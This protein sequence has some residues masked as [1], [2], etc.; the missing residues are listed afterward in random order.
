M[1][2]RHNAA[3]LW[4]ASSLCFF[5][6][7]K[8]GG[9]VVP[10]TG[11]DPEVHLSVGDARVNSRSLPEWMEA[12]INAS[13]ADPFCREVAVYVCVTGINLCPVA[14]MLQY[15]ALQGKHDGPMLAFS[16]GGYLTRGCF[17]T[18]L[19]RALA[20]IGMEC[21]LYVGYRF[22]IGAPT[23]ASMCR[24]QDSLIKTLGCWESSA[25]MV[26]IQTP[27]SSI[28]EVSQTL[29]S[30]LPLQLLSEIIVSHIKS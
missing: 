8:M 24:I 22:R 13:K 10:P 1:T 7:L 18:H 26:Y 4:A 30:Q 6:F 2:D 5:G 12:C 21:R 3:M 16:D 25:Y 17:V 23:T 20:A 28:V 9:V 11:Y 15:M 19:Q 29:T 27:P 14:A